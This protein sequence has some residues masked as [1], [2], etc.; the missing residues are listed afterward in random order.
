LSEPLAVH[1]AAQNNKPERDAGGIEHRQLWHY[2][3]AKDLKC[4]APQQ[5]LV[6]TVSRRSLKAQQKED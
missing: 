4:V 2:S 6:N 3:E 1:T 5:L